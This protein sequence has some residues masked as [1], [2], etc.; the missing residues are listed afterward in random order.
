[1][2]DNNDTAFIIPLVQQNFL[3]QKWKHSSQSRTINEHDLNRDSLIVFNIRDYLP[4]S[5]TFLLSTEKNELK[6]KYRYLDSL[7]SFSS[8]Y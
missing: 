5:K 3:G 8:S 4:N 6:N 2:L 7:L 1:M